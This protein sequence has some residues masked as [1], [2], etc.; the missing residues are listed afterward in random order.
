MGLGRYPAARANFAKCVLWI[1]EAV[2]TMILIRL[3]N[4]QPDASHFRRRYTASADNRR[5]M[6][7]AQP[8]ACAR[9][10]AAPASACWAPPPSDGAV[11]S[12]GAGC[13]QSGQGCR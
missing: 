3:Q 7:H 10:G 13:A 4:Y 2:E 9:D 6:Q 1:T 5:G 8:P 11:S 12:R